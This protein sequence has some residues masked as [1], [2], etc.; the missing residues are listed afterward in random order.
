MALLPPFQMMLDAVVA[1]LHGV[2]A[3]TSVCG[4]GTTESNT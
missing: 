4:S 3:S 1:F 2:M